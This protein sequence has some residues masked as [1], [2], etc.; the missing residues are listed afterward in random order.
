MLI[1][2]VD[3]NSN[4]NKRPLFFHLL[5]NDITNSL[6]IGFSRLKVGKKEKRSEK[7]EKIFY[8]FKY[9]FFSYFNHEE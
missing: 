8:F 6:V 7:N 3:R 4:K 5:T 9:F 2:S 1:G